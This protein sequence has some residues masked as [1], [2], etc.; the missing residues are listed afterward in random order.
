[1]NFSKL[2]K[3]KRNQL[4]LVALGAVIVL[5]ALGFGLIKWQYGTLR[6]LADKREVADRKLARFVDAIKRA[7]EIEAQY[8]AKSR[9]LAH[10]EEGMASGGDLFSWLV[11]AI[12]TFKLEGD[13]KVEMPQI[14][15]PT[16]PSD[17]NLLP[18]FPYKQ[19]TIR[20]GGTAYFHDFGRFIADFEN[21]FPHIRVVNLNL[22][23][24]AG[25]G[26]G[27]ASGKKDRSEEEKLAF[28]MDVVTLVKPGTP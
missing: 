22:E 21:H 8:N 4:I 25:A 3:E 13:Y 10:Q 24:A 23:P 12:R 5:G 27:L 14:S 18:K 9:L 15:Q 28:T 17:V 26:A 7:D 6:T 19:V 20:L 11:N 2:P 1:M 16:S